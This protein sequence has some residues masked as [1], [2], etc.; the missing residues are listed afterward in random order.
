LGFFSDIK[1]AASKVGSA[2]GKSVQTA[3]KTSVKAA[4][5]GTP[6]ED[7]GTA[8]TKVTSKNLS[9]S[10]SRVLKGAAQSGVKSALAQTPLAGNKIAEGLV[11]GAVTGGLPGGP[12]KVNATVSVGAT[13][14]ANSD[15]P[16]IS[17]SSV[18]SV[19]NRQKSALGSPAPKIMSQPITIGGGGSSQAN[20]AIWVDYAT[21]KETVGGVF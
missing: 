6:L 16:P 8:L 18:F 19:L 12:V 11:T 17:P 4:T 13:N 5:K 1:K 2:V 10:F 7:V 3:V 9:G 21:K 14:A 20:R 15:A